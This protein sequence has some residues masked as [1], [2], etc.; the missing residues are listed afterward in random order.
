MG[1]SRE[2][3]DDFVA[4]FRGLSRKFC[5]N[6]DEIARY[7]QTQTNVTVK[8][9]VTWSPLGLEKGLLAAGL[10]G[11]HRQLH[12]VQGATGGE[13]HVDLRAASDL[14]P[15][16]T[17][18]ARHRLRVAPSGCSMEAFQVDGRARGFGTEEASARR[19]SL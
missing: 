8:I 13:Q 16:R 2:G 10:Q 1:V 3:S 4:R 6:F 12:A 11:L 7:K 14:S 17:I 18:R 9:S 19:R 15:A 5:K